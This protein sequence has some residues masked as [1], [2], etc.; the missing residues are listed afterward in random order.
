MTLLVFIRFHIGIKHSPNCCMPKK[1]MVVKLN[2]VP[3]LP[4]RAEDPVVAGGE[5]CQRTRLRAD[6]ADR[7][8]SAGGG[9]RPLDLA[10]GGQQIGRPQ[11]HRAASNRLQDFPTGDSPLERQA[12]DGHG[13]SPPLLEVAISQYTEY[14]FGTSPCQPLTKISAD[15][16]PT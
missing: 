4:P 14:S 11:H 2:P 5:A 9:T 1:N 12:G 10:A 13:A 15:I 6:I 7:D 3:G 16:R 8:G